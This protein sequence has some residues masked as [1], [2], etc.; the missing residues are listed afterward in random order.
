MPML[1]ICHYDFSSLFINHSI[2]NV[3]Y[4]MQFLTPYHPI[5]SVQLPMLDLNYPLD[6]PNIE[7]KKEEKE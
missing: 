7:G 6:M 4:D 5:P 2:Y 1:V 3:D